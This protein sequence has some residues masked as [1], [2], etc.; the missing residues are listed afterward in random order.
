[1]LG[2]WGDAGFGGLRGGAAGWWA[3]ARWRCFARIFGFWVLDGCER[4][5]GLAGVSPLAPLHGLADGLGGWLGWL[6][7]QASFFVVLLLQIQNNLKK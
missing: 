2:W 4:I 5:E 7:L 1:M 6:R 3:R